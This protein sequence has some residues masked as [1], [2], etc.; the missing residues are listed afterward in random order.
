MLGLFN[1]FLIRVVFCRRGGGGTEI[2]Y[3]STPPQPSTAD[4]INAWVKSLPEVYQAQLTYAPQEAAQQVA[5]AQQYAEPLGQAYLKAQRAMYPEE[6]AMRDKLM[7]QVDENL[8]SGV[9]DWMI[10]QYKDNMNAQLGENALSGAGADYVSRGLM[11]QQQDWKNYYTNLGL[12]LTG[13]QPVYSAQTPQTSNYMSNFTPTSNMNYMANT[14]GTYAAAS[15]PVSTTQQPD[16]LGG[17]GGALMGLG[18]MG[19][20]FP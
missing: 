9:P 16:Y 7:T 8:N 13:S 18:M 4:A 20:M 17:A 14:Y 19:L 2:N 6:Y 3:P 15:R 5:L 1:H 11:Q 10:Q 12:S